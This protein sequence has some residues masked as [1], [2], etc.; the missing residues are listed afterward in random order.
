MGAIADGFAAY[1]QPLLDETDGSLEQVK[2]AFAISQ[3]CFNLAVLPEDNRE[4]ALRKMQPHL[5]MNDE[6]P[7][8]QKLVQSKWESPGRVSPGGTH[9]KAKERRRGRATAP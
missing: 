4:A 9:G 7:A 2:K 5:N 6:W 8:P 1:A 3:L